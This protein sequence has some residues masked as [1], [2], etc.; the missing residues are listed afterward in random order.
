MKTEADQGL[1]DQMGIEKGKL[2]F[3]TNPSLFG[4]GE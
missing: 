2:L 1:G 4:V 3:V